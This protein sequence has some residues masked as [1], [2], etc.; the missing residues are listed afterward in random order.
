M[1]SLEAALERHVH[2]S[3]HVEVQAQFGLKRLLCEMSSRDLAFIL[4][5]H[6]SQPIRSLVNNVLMSASVGCSPHRHL[7]VRSLIVIFMNVGMQ[8]ISGSHKMFNSRVDL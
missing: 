1:L 7:S 6:S 5:P 3:R 2:V 4:A 8:D